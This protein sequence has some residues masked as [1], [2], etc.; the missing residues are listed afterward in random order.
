MFMNCLSLLPVI[1]IGFDRF[2]DFREFV[3]GKDGDDSRRRFVCTQTVI[4][5]GGGYRKAE[6]ILVFVDGFDNAGQERQK[7]QVF[8]TGYRRVREG[9]VRYWWRGTSCLCLPLPLMPS[10]GFS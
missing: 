10:K 3:A 2:D 1:G 6:Q 9:L 4:V 8:S 7:L 5:S